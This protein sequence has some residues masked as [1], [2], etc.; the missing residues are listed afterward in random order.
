V[1]PTVSNASE[2]IRS[3]LHEVDELER[4]AEFPYDDPQ[5]ALR[6]IKERL[7]EYL[8]SLKSDSA[9]EEQIEQLCSLCHRDS[10]RS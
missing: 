7:N 10:T 5:E 1:L 9:T 3:F 6:R 8:E 4:K 2:H